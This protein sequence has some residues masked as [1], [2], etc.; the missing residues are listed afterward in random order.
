MPSVEPPFMYGKPSSYNFDGPI[1]RGFNPRAYTQK[2]WT[3]KAPKVKQEGP[4]V[5]FNRH[6]DSVRVS[7]AKTAMGC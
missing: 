1:D 6:P 4:L 2:T 7:T 5:N 3:P